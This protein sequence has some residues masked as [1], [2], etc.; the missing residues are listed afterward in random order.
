[1]IQEYILKIMLENRNVG[2]NLR[3][4]NEIIVILRIYDKLKK[5]KLLF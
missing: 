1:M 5:N 2:P 4:R 3:V